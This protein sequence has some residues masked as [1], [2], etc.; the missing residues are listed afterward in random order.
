MPVDR[1][2]ALGLAQAHRTVVGFAG[3]ILGIFFLPERC[4][5]AVDGAAHVMTYETASHTALHSFVR[6]SIGAYCAAAGYTV[7]RT[8]A[9]GRN[10]AL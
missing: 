8:V 1:T 6:C 7:G 9:D 3:V 10:E 4:I 5:K 2:D